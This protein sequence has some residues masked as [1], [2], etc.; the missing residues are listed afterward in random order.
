MIH[1]IDVISVQ[2]RQ[3]DVPSIV[4]IIVVVQV[5]FVVPLLHLLRVV[6]KM[7]F[8]LLGTTCVVIQ[9][10]QR[11][12]KWQVALGALGALGARVALVG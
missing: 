12:V 10:I 4:Q 9:I 8:N 11:I 1:E 3:Q 2:I 7:G 5:H 6:V